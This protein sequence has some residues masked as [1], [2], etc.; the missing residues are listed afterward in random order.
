MA[1]TRAAHVK[2]L[3]KQIEYIR[4]GQAY[5]DKLNKQIKE[6]QAKIKRDTRVER[7]RA[8]AKEDYRKNSEKYKKKYRDKYNIFF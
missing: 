2:R 5:I 1:T 8:R 3:E 6:I 4:S 7:E